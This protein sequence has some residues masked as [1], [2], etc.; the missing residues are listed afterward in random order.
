MRQHCSCHHDIYWHENDHHL[1]I[2]CPSFMLIK[3]VGVGELAVSDH[4]GSQIGPEDLARIAAQARVGGMLSGKAGL[5][6]MHMG[7]GEDGLKPVFAAVENSDVPI[8]QV[9]TPTAFF[10]CPFSSVCLFWSFFIANIAF[11]AV[12]SSSFYACFLAL[13]NSCQS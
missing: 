2:I 11:Y 7:S 6:Y 9:A 3:A 5:L 10:P 1:T 4:R 13:C 8:E 12:D